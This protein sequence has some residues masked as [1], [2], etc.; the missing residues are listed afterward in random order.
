MMTIFLL[1]LVSRLIIYD[2]H[3]AT[4][5]F[6]YFGKLVVKIRDEESKK[7]V[8]PAPKKVLASPKTFVDPEKT[9][10]V[11]GTYEFFIF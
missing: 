8:V 1:F 10:V 5:G 11:I 6:N 3:S 2:S 4:L 7:V 9:Y